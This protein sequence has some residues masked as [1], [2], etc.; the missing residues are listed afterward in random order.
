MNG[1][2]TF[3]ELTA[4]PGALR[5][6]AKARGTTQSTL[7]L[8]VS[9]IP[10]CSKNV[11]RAMGVTL[12]DETAWSQVNCAV[13]FPDNTVEPAASF[14]SLCQ[15]S[16][17]G[18][19]FRLSMGSGAY[20][21]RTGSSANPLYAEFDILNDKEVIPL[22]GKPKQGAQY[23]AFLNP[24]EQQAHSYSKQPPASA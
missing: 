18:S 4:G 12:S 8:R 16:D 9:S 24:C 13:R 10:P 5:V 17:P 1:D 19:V 15:S 20:A 21:T 3:F 14:D 2:S 6:L 23:H 11:L 22:V 7:K